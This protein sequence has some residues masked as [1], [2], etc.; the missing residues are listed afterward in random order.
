MHDMRFIELATSLPCCKLAANR[1]GHR[2]EVL[3]VAVGNVPAS[4]ERHTTGRS[5]CSEQGD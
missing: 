5:G 3:L 2:R 4:E 1:G